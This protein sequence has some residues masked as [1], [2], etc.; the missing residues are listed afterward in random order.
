V[1]PWDDGAGAGGRVDPVRTSAAV[2][3]AFVVAVLAACGPAADTQAPVAT[4]APPAA[5]AATP[6]PIPATQPPGLATP[7]DAGYVALDATA[8]A[9]TDTLDQLRARHGA[10]NVAPGELPGAEGEVFPG[11]IL[12][13]DDATRR[14]Y[15]YLDDAGAHPVAGRVLDPESHWQRAD[16]VRTGLTLAE[17]AKRNGAPVKFMGFDWD[18]GGNVIGWNGGRLERDPPLGAVT[19]CPPDTEAASAPDYPSGD[20]EFDSANAWVVA[21]PPTVCA[22]SVNFQPPD[23]G[24]GPPP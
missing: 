23:T 7:T 17:L 3:M 10:A 13:P 9:A 11:W 1:R 22:F 5:P 14:L 8:V 15:V 2:A 16:G 18:Y 21:H 24:A 6:L 4:T 20:A 19:L 12:F